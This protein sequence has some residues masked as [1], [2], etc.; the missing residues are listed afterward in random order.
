M[1][2]GESAER[3]GRNSDVQVECSGDEEAQES[4]HRDALRP[5]A[6]VATNGL[7]GPAK[8]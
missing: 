7:F 1:T 8:C 5:A 3:T 4:G 2:S 6:D